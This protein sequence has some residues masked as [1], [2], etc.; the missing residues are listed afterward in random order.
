MLNAPGKLGFLGLASAMGAASG[1]A[2]APTNSVAPVISG[3]TTVGQTL[4]TTNGTWANSPTSYIYQWKRDGSNISSATASTYVLV[5]ADSGAAITCAVTAT[6]AAG[7]AS[8][9]S[10]TLTVTFDPYYLFGNSE[11]GFIFDFTNAATMFT[12]RTGA[13]ATT[14][15]AV[16]GSIGTLKDLSPNTHYLTAA[17]DAAR[18][19]KRQTSTYYN[20]QFDGNDCLSE[21]AAGLYAAGAASIFLVVSA[22]AHSSYI[23]SEGSSSSNAP[24]YALLAGA[25]TSS[26]FTTFIRNDASATVVS[27]ARDM[28]VAFDSTPHLI[29]FVDTGTEQR[30]YLDGVQVASRGYIRSAST[31]DRLGLGALVRAA[32]SNNFTGRIYSAVAV[33]RELTNAELGDLFVW[34]GAKAG[35]TLSLSGGTTQGA[36]TWFNDP[37]AIKVNNRILIGSQTVHGT[38][39]VERYDLDGNRVGSYSLATGGVADDHNNPSFLVRNSDS[40][41]MAFYTGHIVDNIYQRISTSALDASAFDAAVNL[42]ASIGLDDYTYTNPIQLTGET[43]EPIY[44]FFRPGVAGAA[45]S[46]YYTKS[47]DDGSTWSAGVNY[48]AGVGGARPYVKQVRNGTDRIDFI[49]TDGHPNEVTGCSV[50]HFYYEAS[51][52]YATDGT[53]VSLPISLASLSKVWDGATYESWTWDIQIDGSGNPHVLISVFVTT[54]DHRYR[55]GKWNGSSWDTYEICTAGTYLYASQPHYSGGVSFDPNDVTV[56]YASRE[57]GDGKHQ[58]WRYT[59]ADAGVNW[60]G[61]QLTTGGFRKFRP[62]IVRGQTQEPRLAYV[63]GVYASFTV[64]DDTWIALRNSS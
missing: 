59:T 56:V 49:C 58:I 48:V 30:I 39:L 37:R 24:L 63:T 51:K 32:V 26:N 64:L 54:T 43:N 3:T 23:L 4:S 12:E 22:A 53:E 16:D 9:T 57:T 36:W 33:G 31:F 47:T 5:G 50:Y 17:T 18:P 28:G 29:G 34:M 20:A 10:N 14:Q 8:A 7:S 41:I 11:A 35:L 15:T 1:G 19:T 55:Y 27:G 46:P 2:A 38:T 45:I 42:D 62:Y 25:T 44:M 40:K 52:W 6:N 60:S 13:S 21:A 61:S